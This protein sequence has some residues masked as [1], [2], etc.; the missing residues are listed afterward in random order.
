[1]IELTQQQESYDR[2]L[3]LTRMG[4]RDREIA[5]T[6]IVASKREIDYVPANL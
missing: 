2:H 6:G 1:M 3:A 4:G 5:P